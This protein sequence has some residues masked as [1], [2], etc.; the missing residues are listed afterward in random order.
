MSKNI[1]V[2]NTGGTIGS[3]LQGDCVKTKKGVL[4]KKN[5]EYM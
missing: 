2:L 5:T 3:V 1:T 4:S